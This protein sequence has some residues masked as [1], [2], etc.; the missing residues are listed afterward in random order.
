MHL[1]CHNSLKEHTKVKGGPV[2]RR[3]HPRGMLTHRCPQPMHWVAL[4]SPIE[5]HSYTV[6]LEEHSGART[7]QAIGQQ[8]RKA[9]APRGGRVSRRP[10]S[11]G[12]W[13]EV[14]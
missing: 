7:C 5:Q 11:T 12:G 4:S 14:V 3:S 6:S 10:V 13:H 9:L 1:R 2:L 8:R